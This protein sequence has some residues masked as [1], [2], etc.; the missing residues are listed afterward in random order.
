MW[1]GVLVPNL[2]DDKISFNHRKKILVDASNISSGGGI[3]HLK[4]LIERTP[5]NKYKYIIWINKKAQKN[6]SKNINFDFRSSI[7][8]SMPLP[9]RI[10]WKV[11]F[12]R[13]YCSL[14]RPDY[15][16]C[17]G[18]LLF[19]KHKNSTIVFQNI[20]P[21]SKNL[22]EYGF[23][24]RVKNFLL[25]KALIFS[26][27]KSTKVIYHSNDSKQIIQ[28]F[29]K[30]NNC[31]VIPH[32][33]DKIFFIDNL[34]Q[35]KNLKKLEDK[36]ISNKRISFTYIGSA[37]T[38][39]N[40]LPL[41]NLFE[42][43]NK[44][45][46]KFKLNLIITDGP[47]K[48]MI[49]KKLNNSRITEH[50]NLSEAMSK[51]DIMYLLHNNTDIFMFVSSQETFGLILAEGMASGLPI[52]ATKFSCIPEVLGDS[53]FYLNIFN[54][55]EASIKIINGLRNI[56]KIKESAKNS[57][58]RAEKFTWEKAAELSWNFIFE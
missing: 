2:L 31:R 58:N 42:Q 38:Y 46:F 56:Q 49:I 52:F 37:F 50:V 48:N 21:F 26:A 13:Y 28:K 32:G 6:L 24:E 30:N 19:F 17:P 43:L 25:R 34:E 41:F 53:D 4:N 51:K 11:T 27:S 44:K 14:Y 16:F 20:L 15:I 33:I 57:R 39:K 35:E 22:A 23:A 3:S 5:N 36:L 7:F 10:F 12:F 29:H 9:F 54:T 8:F 18:G 55:E 40:F 1:R 45:N 47:K